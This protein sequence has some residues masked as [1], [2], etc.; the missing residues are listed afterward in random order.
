MLQAFVFVPLSDPRPGVPAL[1]LRDWRNW[2]ALMFG[3]IGALLTWIGDVLVV[4]PA[5][6]MYSFF[7]D[8]LEFHQRYIAA[9]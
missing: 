6:F 7:I 9:T 1:Y 8:H 5:E 2:D 3:I 4:R